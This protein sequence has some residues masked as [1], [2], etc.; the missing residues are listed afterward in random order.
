MCG[1]WAHMLSPDNEQ[2]LHGTQKPL[3]NKTE[4][5]VDF[6]NILMPCTDNR[7]RLHDGTQK[8]GY[9]TNL[10]DKIII[11]RNLKQRVDFRHRCLAQKTNTDFMVHKNMVKEV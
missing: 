10:T 5:P 6:R 1:I 2:R 4:Q 8:H 3:L 11:K 7:Q 9:E